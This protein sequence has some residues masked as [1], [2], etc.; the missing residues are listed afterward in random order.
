MWQLPATWTLSTN[1]F[2]SDCFRLQITTKSENE[3]QQRGN[4]S[5]RTT[6]NPAVVSRLRE[7]YEPLLEIALEVPGSLHPSPVFL[8]VSF[9]LSLVLLLVTRWLQ[10]FWI[11]HPNNT[12]IL[13]LKS[14]KA[15]TPAR[16]SPQ[17]NTHIHTVEI[18]CVSLTRVE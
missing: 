18:C 6:E 9:I 3:L 5:R 15:F 4:V 10:Q 16:P 2:Q 17:K 1:L 8:C 14:Q 7:R 13:F 12:L 11:A